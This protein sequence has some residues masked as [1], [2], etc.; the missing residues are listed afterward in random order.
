MTGREFVSRAE[1]FT[2]VGSTNDV[3]RDWLAEGTD[4]VCIATAYEQ[5][6]G[7]GREGRSW[8]APAGRAL[9]ASLGFRPTWLAPGATWRLAASVALAMA[10]A[11]EE[12]AGL[13]AGT[14]WLKWPND[15]VL[16]GPPDEPDVRK[17]AGV[18]GETDGLGT[19]DPRVVIGIGINVD[20]PRHDFPA[21]LANTMTSLRN[22]AVLRPLG[23]DVLLEMFL[24]RLEA[25][26]GALR[27]G[28]F[29]GDAW[30][31]RQVTTGRIVRLLWPD[32]RREDV[33]GLGVDV[34]SGGLIIGGL[35]R[36]HWPALRDPN[37]ATGERTIHIGEIHH[38][39]LAS[40]IAVTA[41]V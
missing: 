25:G 36:L 39:R 38:V 34:A 12:H 20:W 21:A 17:L 41:G 7:R 9:L 10:E 1:H 40:G 28:W 6:A 4:E 24:A 18:L 11:A 15:L 14:V 26:L 2:R 37:D 8:V 19:G 13:A 31:D 29:A 30:R 5:T 22:A 35:E 16:G 32:G 3:V 23:R 27:V 33:L